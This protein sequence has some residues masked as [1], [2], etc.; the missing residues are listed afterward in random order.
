VTRTEIE[1][2]R[3]DLKAINPNAR[4]VE[5]TRT[6]EQLLD[7]IEAKGKEVADAVVKLREVTGEKS[8]RPT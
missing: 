4:S 1:T 3:Y 2:K 7:L 6:P 5:D 8:V